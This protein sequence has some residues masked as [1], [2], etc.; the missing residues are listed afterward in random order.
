MTPNRS[1]ICAVLRSEIL[2]G[3]YDGYARFPSEPLLARRF[4]VSRSTITRALDRLKQ[5]GLLVSRKGSGSRV[6]FERLGGSRCIG[7]LVPGPESN[8]F[9]A[10]IVKGAQAKCRE[11]GYEPLLRRVTAADGKV[12]QRR[13]AASVAREFVSRHVDGVVLFPFAPHLDINEFILEA[14]DKVGIAVLLVNRPVDCH[15][16]EMCDLVCVDNV[17]AGRQ[18]ARHLIERGARRCVFLYWPQI[19]S[20]HLRYIGVA[21]EFAEVRGGECHKVENRVDSDR[22]V[23][24]WV[25]RFKPQAFACGNDRSA[26]RLMGALAR[27]GINVPSDIMVTGFDGVPIESELAGKLTTI[28]Q[29]LA[30][31]GSTAITRLVKRM[32]NRALPRS[33]ILLD[34][35][36]VVR[37]STTRTSR[38]E[39][40]SKGK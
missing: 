22:T 33:T 37:A 29:P 35:L 24:E 25:R 31:I 13:D 19:E 34:A 21:S 1:D 15:K 4:G 9:Y 27:G 10:G 23:M 28:V 2:N 14:L 8:D 26:Y 18:V 38:T 3:K 17:A 30:E 16:G 36:L 20:V 6:R 39:A 40:K 12:R 7:I 11:L 32:R 5:D